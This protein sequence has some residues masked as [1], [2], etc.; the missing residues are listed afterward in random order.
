M[1]AATA[2][3][4]QALDQTATA[5]D[6]DSASGYGRFL[7]A[8]A[9]ALTSLELALERDGVETWL[10]DWPRR[11]RRAVLHDDLAA[12]NLPIPT[13]EAQPAFSQAFAVGVLYVLE[14]SRLGA[15]LIARR[16]RSSG[17]TLPTGYLTHG[18]D[19][20]LWR[21]F[22]EWLESQQK[23]GFRTD[24]AV[25]GA[26]YGFRCF[27]AAVQPVASPGVSNVRAGA[28]ARI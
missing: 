17:P 28:D 9:A 12:M 8:S 19:F 13:L 27:A 7:S 6:F 3:D 15:R 14:G 25:A 20:N 5:L 10:A 11:R 23:V 4:H 24:E 26:R 2:G 1:R 16:V 22:L 18:E 21:S